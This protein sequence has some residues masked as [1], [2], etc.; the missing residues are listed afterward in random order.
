MPKYGSAPKKFLA[1]TVTFPGLGPFGDVGA[2]QASSELGC[3]L[4]RMSVVLR[5]PRRLG[6]DQRTPLRLRLVPLGDQLR[7]RS[8]LRRVHDNAMRLIVR[9]DD[10][11]HRQ[12]PDSCPYG[13]MPETCASMASATSSSSQPWMVKCSPPWANAVP[14][15]PS[16]YAAMFATA[17]APRRAHR[18]FVT[19]DSSQRITALLPVKPSASMGFGT[20]LSTLSAFVRAF[21]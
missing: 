10:V 9:V 11:V 17:R 14:L 2:C 15:W 6:H 19:T 5:Y 13:F 21:F 7:L 18:F 8:V 16:W 4:R 20:L 1:M 12:N 3:Q